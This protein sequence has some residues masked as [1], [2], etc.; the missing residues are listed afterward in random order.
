MHHPGLVHRKKKRTFS[1]YP[2]QPQT[3]VPGSPFAILPLR[4]RNVRVDPLIRKAQNARAKTIC[5][6]AAAEIA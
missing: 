1:R 2:L 5:A 4:F 6:G 3:R